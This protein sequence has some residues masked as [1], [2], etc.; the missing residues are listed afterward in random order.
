MSN[1][2]LPRRPRP[3]AVLVYA[4]EGTRNDNFDYMPLPDLL[5]AG[6][7]RGN[8]RQHLAA[9]VKNEG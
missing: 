7:G 2:S 9:T 8:W 1:T 4:R 5:P 3:V 6:V